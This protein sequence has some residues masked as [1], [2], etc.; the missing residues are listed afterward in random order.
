MAQQ[1]IT[2]KRQRLTK[3]AKADPYHDFGS[4]FNSWY[5]SKQANKD[6]FLEGL[7]TNFQTDNDDPQSEDAAFSMVI[8]HYD[9]ANQAH[10][11]NPKL[12]GNIVDIDFANLFKIFTYPDEGPPALPGHHMMKIN[13]ACKDIQNPAVSQQALGSTDP[14]LHDH[15]GT[16]CVY[17]KKP[18]YVDL[19]DKL[20]PKLVKETNEI[21][22][23]N[24]DD[25]RYSVKAR[26]SHI[27]TKKIAGTIHRTIFRYT[28]KR[29]INAYEFLNYFGLLGKKIVLVVDAT[30]ISIIEILQNMTGMNQ[31]QIAA[32]K[33]TRIYFAETVETLSDSATK[34]SARD[35]QFRNPN[36][37]HICSC[38]TASGPVETVNYYWN[39]H[40]PQEIGV[41]GGKKSGGAMAKRIPRR[42]DSKL[43]QDLFI[44]HQRLLGLQDINLKYLRGWNPL[45]N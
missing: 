6:T 14:C 18:G 8:Q 16:N 35:G 27:Y 42:I 5:R 32:V 28:E 38:Y 4:V 37:P 24:F 40:S 12:Q 22:I 10:Q 9:P 39:T 7:P 26:N 36:T 34:S 44:K 17:Y 13:S 15:N 11:N 19:L 3:L 21:E 31:V 43:K 1:P 29:L 45:V 25:E 23:S 30:A 2:N 41:S 20:Q 33:E